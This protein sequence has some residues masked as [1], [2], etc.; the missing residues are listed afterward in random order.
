MGRLRHDHFQEHTPERLGPEVLR[1]LERGERIAAP[2]CVVV[3]HPDDETLGLGSR[4]GRLDDLT[5]VHLTDG[6]PH[7]DGDAV[8]AGFACAADYAAAR[9][10]ELQAALAALGVAPR[11]VRLGLTDQEAVVHLA[12]LTARLEAL[13]RGAALV[14][15]HAYEGGHPDHDAAAFAV[16]AA[17]RRLASRGLGPP[18]RLEFAG[19][20]LSAG[21]RVTGA[22]W[23]DP[24][25]PAVRAEIAAHALAAKRAA[26]AAHRSQAEVLA[27]F[28]AE[29]EAFRLAPD[30][31]FAAPPPPGE[32]LY[33]RWGWPLTSGLWRRC[34]RAALEEPTEAAAA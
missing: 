9:E 31:D 6:A 5:L 1:A 21:E 10:A 4:L 34:A 12:G 17:C 19:Y 23:P 32:A 27:W 15:T 13:L 18:L 29:Q 30:Y 25:R 33:D 7:A 11:R 14:I 22:F 16:Q 20:H 28:D 26:L 2:C 8:R 3:A 24:R